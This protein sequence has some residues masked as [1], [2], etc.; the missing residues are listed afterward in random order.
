MA[1]T[2][3]GVKVTGSCNLG[4]A[5]LILHGGATMMAVPLWM[6][7]LLWQSGITDARGQMAVPTTVSYF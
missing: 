7:D 4:L 1:V 5:I 3:H 2:L 6:E